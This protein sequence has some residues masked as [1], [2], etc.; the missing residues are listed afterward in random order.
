[1]KGP[2]NPDVWFYKS[3]LFAKI[4]THP[5]R[6]GNLDQVL[7]I[8]DISGLWSFRPNHKNHLSHKFG[9]FRQVLHTV[10]KRMLAFLYKDETVDAS[11]YRDKFTF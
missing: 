7:L 11:F 5:E 8:T 6:L 3:S 1:M 2:N 9:S 4:L 10:Q